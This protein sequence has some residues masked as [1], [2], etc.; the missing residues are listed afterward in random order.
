MAIAKQ[1]KTIVGIFS[2]VQ[3][4][5]RAAHD[6]ENAGISRSDIS[7]VASKNVVGFDNLNESSTSTS[8]KTSDVVADAGIGAAIGGVGGLLLSAAGMMTLPVI[9]PVLAAGPIV[10]ALTG[11]GVGAAAGGLIAALT[12]AGIPEEDAEHYAEGIRRGDVLVSVHARPGEAQRIS[13]IMDSA[14]AVDVDSRLKDWKQEGWTGYS[15]AS[16]PYS[17]DEIKRQRSSY[18]ENSTMG[19]SGMA[20]TMGH[21]T[22]ETLN[23]AESSMKRGVTETEAALRDAGNTGN[24]RAARIY[25][26]PI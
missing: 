11:A 14:G 13:D 15:P 16:R 17:A 20:G 18:G 23:R 6:L 10:A 2:S 5:Q 21:R 22:Q 24:R 25:D 4:A 19:T 26:R 7:V 3:D 9:G 12:E 8:S 1:S